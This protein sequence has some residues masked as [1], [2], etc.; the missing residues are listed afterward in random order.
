MQLDRHKLTERQTASTS[1]LLYIHRH[2][3]KDNWGR[4]PL[5]ATSAFTQLRDSEA[6]RQA[7]DLI[8]VAMSG[9]ETDTQRGRQADRQTAR[10][11]GRQAD[12]QTGRQT[13]RQAGRQ[14][15]RQT[16]RQT[17]RQAGRQADGQTDR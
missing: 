1:R 17:G 3:K 14:A 11:V 4:E 16:D 8:I 15:G 6:S 2:Q 10:Q 7:A 13:G 9:S 5:T 12:G